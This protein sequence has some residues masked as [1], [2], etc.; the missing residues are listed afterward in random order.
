MNLSNKTPF[1]I[2]RALFCGL[3]LCPTV[4]YAQEGFGF[5]GAE[6]D[7]VDGGFGFGAASESTGDAAGSFGFAPSAPAASAKLGGAAINGELRFNAIGF[8]ENTD[9][10]ER[11]S[12][13]ALSKLS[14]S[15]ADDKAELIIDLKL[16]PSLL[17]SDP[18]LI[19]DQAAVK[20]Y[21]GPLTLSGG[22]IKTSWG[23]ADAFSALDVL[24]PQDLS[25]LSL[26]DGLDRKIA[27]PMISAKAALGLSAQIETVFLPVFRGHKIAWS[28]PWTA[29]AVRDQK[30]AASALLY[31]GADPLA[32]SGRGNGLYYS[33]YQSA[34]S[35]AWAAAYDAAYNAVFNSVYDTAFSTGYTAL[36]DAFGP[37][38]TA[39][40]VAAV[41]DQA[42]SAAADA[43]ASQ[44]KAYADAAC[45]D[46]SSAIAAEARAASDKRL[47]ELLAY[48]DT[49]GFDYFQAG[50]RLTGAAGPMDLG[51]Q[52][53][54]G[55][56]PT[57][58]ANADPTAFIEAGYKVPLSYNRYHH[59][60][61][62]AAWTLGA[63]AFRAEAALNLTEDM[64]GDKPLIYNPFAAWSLGFDR[65]LFAG[66]TF[67][68][69]GSGTIRL[70]NDKVGSGAYDIEKG[71]ALSSTKII[72][73]L[74]H[75]LFRDTVEWELAAVY[76]IE[77]K[78][79]ML[80]P[81][82]SWYLGEGSLDLALRW[83]GG[84]ADG[85]LGQFADRSYARLGFSYKF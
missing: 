83:F 40:Q 12:A 53:F 43:A 54:Y 55:Y 29:K 50:L 6:S 77:D 20:L 18:A 71:Q 79:F 9:E 38:H 45:A 84:D 81:R 22:L 47:S 70:Y 62:D 80:A 85:E 57:P 4:L 15:A 36:T 25:D 30:T 26:D 8:I 2:I 58:A 13:K 67:N 56:L 64:A 21:S 49:S 39:A 27:V 28:G 33:Y 31:Y 5:G 60:G 63:F 65:E 3:L 51:A 66:F 16:D 19:V 34:W 7:G 69:Q 61:L 35:T 82:L 11:V 46:N 75:K 76:G 78:D 14:F 74:R 68:A 52:Y 59:A 32:N 10:L 17:S 72:I 1:L 24:N 73:D 37:N 42:F 41:I 48:P 44:V 23:K